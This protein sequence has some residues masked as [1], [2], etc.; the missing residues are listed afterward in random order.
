MWQS[1]TF[2]I[3]SFCAL[4]PFPPPLSLYPFIAFQWATSTA[5]ALGTCRGEYCFSN[6]Q[7]SKGCLYF[8]CK[9]CRQLRGNC[10][11]ADTFH[12]CWWSNLQASSFICFLSL[13]CDFKPTKSKKKKKKGRMLQL[14]A[15][16][17]QT[18]P[19]PFWRVEFARRL[20]LIPVLAIHS[21]P[22]LMLKAAFVFFWKVPA[23]MVLLWFCKWFKLPC[24]LY[25]TPLKNTLETASTGVS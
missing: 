19:F 3:W 12:W 20:Y 13:P 6:K 10:R 17:L 23:F 15:S 1:I 18:Q 22:I 7:L 9:K 16:L 11:Q 14:A 21:C 8:L 24:L 5:A 2:H 4:L 25:S